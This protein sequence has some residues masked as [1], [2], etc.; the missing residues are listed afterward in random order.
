MTDE[1]VVTLFVDGDEI[2]KAGN[3]MAAKNVNLAIGSSSRA[4]TGATVSGIRVYSIEAEK[5]YTVRF[6][7]KDGTDV[8]STQYVIQ[9]EDAEAPVPPRYEGFI[10]IGWS[11]TF[12]N[13]QED[14]TVYPR[15]RKIPPHPRHNFY[16]S[17]EDGGSGELI[18]S[19]Q[20][21]N[22]CSIVQKLDGECTIEYTL[23]TRQT[24]GVVSL[25]DRVE[26]EGLVFYVTEIK[27]SISSGICYTK[28]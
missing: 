28:M 25:K 22:A 23:M 4:A 5:Y 16:S 6:L 9:G 17:T 12:K 24:E 3:K 8:I 27:K 19:Y 11:T 26:V 13:E 15:Y 10:F 7:N 21:V 14:M 18:K 2:G 20:G 1:G